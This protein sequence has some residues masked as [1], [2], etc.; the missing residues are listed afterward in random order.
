MGT[1]GNSEDP[2][3]MPHNAAFHQDLHCFL[4][5]NHSSEKE[6]E[7]FWDIITSPL[8]MCIM[9]ILPLLYAASWKIPLV[10]NGLKISGDKN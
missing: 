10:L 4:K 6:T 2:D 7:Y 1:L 9:D 5:Q 3:E 8:N